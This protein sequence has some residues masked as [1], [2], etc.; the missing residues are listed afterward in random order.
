MLLVLLP[1]IKIFTTSLTVASG[2]SGGVYVPALF[3]GAYLGGAMGLLFH[4]LFPGIVTSIA[5]FVVIGMMSVFAAAGKVPLS[6]IIMVTEMTGSLQ[7]LPGAMVAVSLAYLVSG[8]E[9]I[10]RA[11]VPTRRDSPAHRAEYEVP[12]MRE[13]KVKDCRLL[14]ASVPLEAT[15]DEARNFMQERGWTSAPVTDRAGNFVGL[16]Y[17]RELQGKKGEESVRKYVLAGVT[18]V[19]QNSSLEHALEIMGRNGT[20]WVSVVEGDKF[21]G[22]L[23][24][25]SLLEAYEREVVR[26]SLDQGPGDHGDAVQTHG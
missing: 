21:V 18:T 24:L 3:I 15:V 16:V 5:P 13:L 7:V 25:D 9:T 19:S 20:N 26:R 2:G 14:Q 1:F 6:M 23:T 10:N 22:V 4:S 8:N 12:V 17:M 11:Q